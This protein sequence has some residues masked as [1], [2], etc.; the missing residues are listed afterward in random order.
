MLRVRGSVLHRLQEPAP[1]RDHHP[2]GGRRSRDT[3]ALGDRLRRVPRRS[4]AQPRSCPGIGRSCGP[5]DAPRPSW[6]P[7]ARS[8][9]TA[10]SRS[11]RRRD[12]QDSSGARS[13]PGSVPSLERCGCRSPDTPGRRLCVAWPAPTPRCTARLT[14]GRILDPGRR[15]STSPRCS[16][17]RSGADPPAEPSPG[18][19]SGSVRAG[20]ISALG[21]SPYCLV[22]PGST[23]HPGA[24]H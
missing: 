9:P 21:T 22:T 19:L 17:W 6:S 10:S 2:A 12:G 4:V 8:W 11:G 16:F 18:D 24:E 20:F 3:E 15:A 13:C 5:P 23:P 1:A 14:G 7:R